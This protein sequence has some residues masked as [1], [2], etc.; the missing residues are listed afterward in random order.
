MDL[1]PRTNLQLALLAAGVIVFAVG[2]RWENETL[3]LVAVGIFAAATILR[4]VK[5]PRR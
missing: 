1:G 5:N 4:F 2:Q 3:T